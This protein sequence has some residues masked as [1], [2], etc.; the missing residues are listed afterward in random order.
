MHYNLFVMIKSDSIIFDLKSKGH[1]ITRARKAI[2][3]I[4]INSSGPIKATDI[5][6]SLDK[7]KLK[8]DKTTV[9]RELEFAKKT[10]DR[11]RGL[12]RRSK[13]RTKKYYTN[14]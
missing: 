14:V 4:F 5:K 13:Y 1:R 6:L 9:Y 7:I 11:T 2:I 10:N 12:Y 8:A 3:D